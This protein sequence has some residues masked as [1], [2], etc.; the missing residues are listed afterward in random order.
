M[1]A[2]LMP[3]AIDQFGV[4]FALK[5]LALCEKLLF[6]YAVTLRLRFEAVGAGA[7]GGGGDLIHVLLDAFCLVEIPVVGRLV[8]HQNRGV[9]V[10][11]RRRC[12]DRFE[13]ADCRRDDGENGDGDGHLHQ[14]AVAGMGDMFCMFGVFERFGRRVGHG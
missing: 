9:L 7:A 3:L 1:V 5:R 10:A 11:D 8:L 12:F 4:G 6:I 14:E 13:T 2:A